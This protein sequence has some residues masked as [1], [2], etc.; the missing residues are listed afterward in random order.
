MKSIF[1]DLDGVFAHF[2]QY[3]NDYFGIR[4]DSIPDKEMWR[5][6]NEHGKFF[7]SLPL[8]ENAL[9]FYHDLD[10]RTLNP[11]FFLTACPK[12]NY[13]EAAQ[14]KIRWVKKNIDEHAHVLPV[15]GG[16]NKVLFMANK[17]DILIDDFA[18]NIHPWNDAGGNG[19]IHTD[20]AET[21]Y[22]L[23]QIF[24]QEVMDP[25]RYDD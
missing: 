23:N 1:L 19:I 11:I 5:L 16:K 18:K 14:Q 12:S 9:K 4:H 3:F 8:M 2:E 13:Q 6:I 17:G 10:A 20:F 22:Q 7:E 25:T 24:G 15:M 21:A